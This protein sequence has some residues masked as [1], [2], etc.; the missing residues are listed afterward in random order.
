MRQ[1]IIKKIRVLFLCIWLVPACLNAQDVKLK[2]GFLQD[3]IRLGDPIEYYL[4]ARYP[5]DLT[6]LF[7]DSTYKFAPFEFVSKKYFP[8]QTRQFESYDSAVYQ[9][10][11]F[12][13][14]DV[15]YL[16]LPAF[17]VNPSDCTRYVP[18]RDSVFLKSMIREPIPDSLAAQ[19]LPLKSNTLYNRVSFLF[20]YPVLVIVVGALFFISIIVWIVFGKKIKKYFRLRKL[21]KNHARFHDSFSLLLSQLKS[22]YAP[23][24]TE[25]AVSLWKKYLEE[26]ERKPY[27]KLTTRETIRLEKDENLGESLHQLDMA[28]YGNNRAVLSPLEHLQQVARERLTRKIEEVKYG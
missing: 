23:D 21:E 8:T 28:I 12:E 18:Q 13:V 22:H 5:S 25:E 10:Q 17:V 27:T 7:P 15:Q 14:L 6:V 1:L 16:S 26:L 9:F 20:N 3:S 2:S 24:R 19:D 4:V 11:T